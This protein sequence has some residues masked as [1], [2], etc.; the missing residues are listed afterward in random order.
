MMTQATD[1]K[2]DAKKRGL[3]RGLDSLLPRAQA[4]AGGAAVAPAHAPGR[5]PAAGEAV[6]ELPL[7]A[8]HANPYQTRARMREDELQELAA[9]IQAQGV[10]QPILVRK[11]DD[12]RYHLI[13]GERRWRASKMAGKTT[14]PAI[15]KQVSNEQAMEMT[16]IENL[17]REDLSCM[18]QARAFDRLAREF[19]LTQDQIAAKTGKERSSVGNYLRLLKLPGEVQFQIE[20][21]PITF[22]HARVLM[23]LNS[24]EHIEKAAEKIVKDALS[25]R[26]LE[27]LCFDLNHPIQRPPEPPRHVDPNVRA[28]ERQM[29]ASLGVRVQIKDRNGKG[30]IVIQ[31]ATLEDFDRVVA[32]LGKSH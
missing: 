22:S 11:I 30:K 21:G 14:I 10:V 16:I 8:V 4:P 13:A 5:D 25:V 28:A 29:E 3:G 9:S 31:Y 32:M 1:N 20:N 15:V 12:G 7:E 23:T 6:L 2:T 24:A 17:Q 18:E 19:G 27:D 26:Q